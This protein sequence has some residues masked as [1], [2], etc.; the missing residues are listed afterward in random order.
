MMNRSNPPQ[1]VDSGRGIGFQ[2][3]GFFQPAVFQTEQRMAGKMPTPQKMPTPRKMPTPLFLSDRILV[4]A[5]SLLLCLVWCIGCGQKDSSNPTQKSTADRAGAES[6][7][8]SGD[9]NANRK[10]SSLR[11]LKLLEGSKFE[12]A[13]DEC[14]RV[15]LGSPKDVRALYVAANILHERKK[16]DAALQMVDRIE[17]SDPEFGLKSHRDSAK[18]CFDAKEFVKAEARG[19]RIIARYPDDAE[20]IKTLAT[21]L[22]LQGRRYEASRLDQHLVRLGK[23]DLMILI[24]AV[25]TAKPINSDDVVMKIIEDK[26]SQARMRSSLAFGKLYEKSPEEAEALFREVLAIDG[27][28]AAC[29]AGLGQSLIGQEKFDEI[30][31]WLNRANVLELE[32]LPS[33]WQ[34]LG[35]ALQ[36]SEHFDEAIYCLTKSVELDPFDYIAVGPLSQCLLAAGHRQE[37]IAAESMFAETQLTNR[38]VNYTRDGFRRPEWMLQIADALESHGR[39]VEGIAWREL[40][41]L[42][43]DKDPIRIEKLQV[44]RRQLASSTQARSLFSKTNFAWSSDSLKKPDLV[45]LLVSDASKNRSLDNGN[46][47]VSSETVAALRWTNV[48]QELGIQFQYNNGDDAK[49]I[50]M[51]T[52]QSNGAGAAAIDFDRDGWCDIYIL[53]G[54]GDPRFPESNQPCALVRNLAGTRFT[55]VATLARVTNIAY[56]QGAAAG[57]WDQDGFTDLFVLN[58]GQNRLYRNMGDGTFEQVDVPEMKRDIAQYPVWSVSGAIADINGDHLPDLVE[59]N[60]SSGIEVIT[61]LCYSQQ[62]LPQVCRPTEFPA[63]KDY[64][65]LSDG[66]GAFHVAND[67]W[68]L[69]LDDGRGLGVIV[70]NLDSTNGN[71]I[72]IANDMS[73]NNLLISSP[74]PSKLHRFTLTDEAIRRG[75]AVDNQGKPQASM[76]VA[77]ADIDRNGT[78]DLFMTNFI[79]EYNAL[80]LQTRS[81]FFQDASR[82]YRL[83]DPKKANLGFGTQLNDLDLD[84]WHDI[85]LVNGHVDDYR[86]TGQPFQMKPQVFLQRAGV[87]VD[88]SAQVAGE[89]FQSES[90]GRCLGTIDFNRDGKLDFFATHLDKPFALLRNDSRLDGSWI[91]IDIVG[92]R[93]EREAIGAEVKVQCGDQS[94]THQRLAGNGFECTNEP[95]VFLGLGKVNQIDQLELHWPSGSVTTLHDLKP[96]RRYHIVEELGS[97]FVWSE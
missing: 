20:S 16:L 5:A 44:A 38:N 45:A 27:A 78:L 19:H 62:K 32:A 18:W 64:I 6:K 50:G 25:D 77:C 80:Y 13:W 52:Y 26:P 17:L 23:F 41:E 74:D 14:Q 58:F 59:V 7:A 53:Q 2:P 35:L 1:V 12:E 24:L 33:Y 81:H 36:H 51:Q 30:P 75:C 57:D 69:G 46:S 63:S 71:D 48:A 92:T 85:F 47:N 70:G 49:T 54:G 43:S 86:A 10:P 37:S 66:Q 93:S 67:D 87:F 73:A 11:A 65:Y 97:E 60:Y 90:L 40:C 15:L 61:H 29:Y 79:E 3:V 31:E 28:P 89:F 39:S 68:N 91:M 42:A 34:V 4:R 88:S 82:R 94:W 95:F 56:G 22:D 84:G 96:N 55:D 9:S 76:G 72:Y 83:I 8:T 21:N